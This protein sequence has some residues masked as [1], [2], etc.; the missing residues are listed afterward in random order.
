MK[1]LRERERERWGKSSLSKNPATI[2]D[3]HN[4]FSQTQKTT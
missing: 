3:K 1:K 4:S 2:P